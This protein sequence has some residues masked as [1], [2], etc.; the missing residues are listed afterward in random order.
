MSSK[1]KKVSKLGGKWSMGGILGGAL[2]SVRAGL[3]LWSLA[4]S[5]VLS[6]HAFAPQRG[7]RIQ[8]ASADSA[9]P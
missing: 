3:R 9:G 1:F 7:R 4:N 5:A 8:S 6:Y 2:R